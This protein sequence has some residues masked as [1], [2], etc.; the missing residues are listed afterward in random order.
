M[1]FLGW[2]VVV[3]STGKAPTGPFA[4][5]LLAQVYWHEGRKLP[6]SLSIATACFRHWQPGWSYW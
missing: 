6:V 4:A 3:T 1:L 5:L 2:D